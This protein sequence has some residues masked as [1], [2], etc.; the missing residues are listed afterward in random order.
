MPR[1][2]GFVGPS[3]ADRSLPVDAEEAINLYVEKVESGAGLNQAVLR[4]V[5][6]R[7]RWSTLPDGP[8]RALFA[9]DNRAF[10][11]AGAG[12]YEVF[13]NGAYT[14]LGPVER[15][16]NP[17]AITS[18]GQNGNQL[19]IVSG[20]YGYILSLTTGTL[21][22]PL[23]GGFPSN[24]RGA[25]H[26]DTYFLTRSGNAVHASPL[27][28]GLTWS[29]SS[30]A[31]RSIAS[32]DLQSFL[33][34]DHRVLWYIGSKT[35]E[36]WYNAALSP[37]AFTPVPSAFMGHGTCAPDAVVRF[38]NSVFLIGQNENGDR[39][40]FLIGSGYTAQRISTHS[41]EQAW[42][43][44]STVFDAR[45]WVYSEAGHVFVVVT[46]PT[47]NATWCYD[48]STQLW[49]RRGR[50]NT[51]RAQYDADDGA[52]HCYAFGKHLVG[53]RTNGLIYDQSSDVYTDDSAP[54]RWLRRA[55]YVTADRRWLTFDR[56][57]LLAETGVGLSTGQGSDPLV[58]MRYS[59][60]GGR[61]WSAER[62]RTMGALGQ[63]TTTIEWRRMGRSRQRVFEVAGS[64]P[65]KTTLI[66]AFVDVR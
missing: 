1:L 61:T 48:A 2:T 65:V 4:T 31:Q 39:Y 42:R 20:G 58:S 47:A 35:S 27:N 30:K 56:F 32:D 29:A 14:S 51:A 45:A 59:D 46:F 18:N 9:A 50:W 54:I 66:D 25:G 13:S 38:D 6:G 17:A 23:G 15:D 52:C 36:P 60:D 19:F 49:H 28:D 11:V 37:F 26:V 62:L 34:D 10:C 63:Y 33:V 64:E 22:G 40:A 3:Y 8:V 57:E 24:A 43:S 7:S 41:V 12:L 5:P 53:S 55:P 21:T 44:Y 16:D